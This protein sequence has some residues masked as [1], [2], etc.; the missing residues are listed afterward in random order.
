MKKE[1]EEKTVVMRFSTEEKKGMK[2]KG[3]KLN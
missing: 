2:K 1:S 3:G